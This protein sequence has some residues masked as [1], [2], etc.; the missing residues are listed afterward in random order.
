MFKKFGKAF[1]FSLISTFFVFFSI[2]TV[3][4]H[5]GRTDSNGGHYCRTNC[6]SWRLSY[7]EYHFHDS[8]KPTTFVNEPSTPKINVPDSDDSFDWFGSGFLR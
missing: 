5:P 7:D 3:S 4:A 1:I 2:G 6:P 8:K